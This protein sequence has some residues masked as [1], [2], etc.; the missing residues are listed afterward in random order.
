MPKEDADKNQKEKKEKTAKD[1]RNLYLAREG[2]VREG[3][4]AAEGMSKEDLTKR[5]Q[6]SRWKKQIL[7]DLTMFVIA[8]FNLYIDRL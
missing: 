4:L 8:R 3:T 5:N 1:T 2:L 7:K 6:L